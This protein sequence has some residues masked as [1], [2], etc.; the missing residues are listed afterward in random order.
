MPYF[1]DKPLV[2]A[3]PNGTVTFNNPGLI[4]D[5]TGADEAW[6]DGFEGWTD[7]VNPVVVQ[8]QKAIGDGAFLAKRLYVQGRLITVEGMIATDSEEGTEDAW[9]D[10][11]FRAFPLNEDIV[12]T[13]Q[14]PGI[15][16]FV[17]GRL[18]SQVKPT[19]FM[20]NGF[21][22]TLDFLCPDPYKYDADSTLFGTAGIVGDSSGGMEF[23]LTFPIV[24]NGVPAGSG[25]QII[26]N[27]I[28][29]AD[30]FP[31][32]TVFGQ[33]DA[34]WRIENE[35]SGE[36]LSFDVDTTPLN[37]MVIDSKAETA[38]IDGSPVTGLVSG[39]FFT[40]KPG[41]NVLKLFGNY[42]PD[43]TWSVSAKSAWR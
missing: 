34:G 38:N 33:L 43:T 14:G 32:F 7:S 22:F 1:Q 27:N 19:Q 10:L 24:F 28:G 20:P 26:I 29:N 11:V 40:L 2:V 42:F 41:V 35:T 39:D 5:L 31:T 4:G 12:M 23:P 18:I 8:S 36:S 16:K 3:S 25:N 37:T 6:I 21:R 30:T 13:H 9:N 15:H 17:T